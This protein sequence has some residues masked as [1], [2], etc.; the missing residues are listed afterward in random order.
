MGDLS[1][2]IQYSRS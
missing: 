2:K 1:V